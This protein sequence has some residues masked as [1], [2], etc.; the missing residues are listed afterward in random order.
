MATRNILI[1]LL[2]IT[3]IPTFTRSMNQ[4]HQPDNDDNNEESI[5]EEKLKALEERIRRKEE[6]TATLRER[7]RN[8]QIARKEN[9]TLLYSFPTIPNDNPFIEAIVNKDFSK[10]NLL[11]NKDPKLIEYESLIHGH[12]PL[13]FAASYSN[14][15]IVGLLLDHKSADT[16]VQA[17]NLTTPA[18]YAA[19][20]GSL[21]LVQLLE[22]R[23]A[24]LTAK[25]NYGATVL[26]FATASTAENKQLLMYLLLKGIPVDENDP[27]ELAHICSAFPTFSAY[28]MPYKKN[29]LIRRCFEPVDN[30]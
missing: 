30:A 28:P 8:A 6:E 4:D 29:S 3:S 22:E 16:N 12:R 18:H 11:L 10:A 17:N 7:L 27:K 15:P 23:G 14:L 24:D 13:H 21:P 2:V 5:E 25:T 26:T 1:I 19:L 20:R 9:G